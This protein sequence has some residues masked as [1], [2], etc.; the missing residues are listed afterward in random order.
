MK[1]VKILQGTRTIHI[2]QGEQMKTK[3][4]NCYAALIV[5]MVLSVLSFL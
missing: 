5:F 4:L 3:V 2:I 1:Q